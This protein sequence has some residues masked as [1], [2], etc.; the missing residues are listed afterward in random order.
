MIYVLYFFGVL[1]AGFILASLYITMKKSSRKSRTK[2]W[3][4]GDVIYLNWTYTSSAI[5]KECQKLNLSHVTLSGWNNDNV[6]YN[7]GGK[8]FCEEWSSVDINKSQKW[9]DYYTSCEEFMGMEPGFDKGVREGNTS[10]NI[11]DMI[12]GHPI[13]TMT[14]TLCQVYLNKAIQ[15]ENYEL[16]DKLR[17]RME[18]F[19]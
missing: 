16:A 5:N 13:A 19:R 4:I 1:V 7:V 12:D 9:R 14:E 17:K 11:S 8:V 10:K 15:E 18:N 6:F 2:D 3:Q